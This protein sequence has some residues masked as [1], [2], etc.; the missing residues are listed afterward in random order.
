[1]KTR[2]NRGKIK[3]L[4]RTFRNTVRKGKKNK[5]QTKKATYCK[6]KKQFSKTKRG[7]MTADVI[8]PTRNYFNPEMKI[9]LRKKPRLL[10]T[11]NKVYYKPTIRLFGL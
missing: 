10:G 2:R 4:L 1:M 11:I 9:L 8:H 7:N 3:K 6:Q 5:K